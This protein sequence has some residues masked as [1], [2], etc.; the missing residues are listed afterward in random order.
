MSTGR[1]HRLGLFS[2][3][4]QYLASLMQRSD[5]GEPTYL[6]D[7][8]WNDQT[9]ISMRALQRFAQLS[10][11]GTEGPDAW[12]L[13][14]NG[15]DNDFLLK[16]GN[17]SDEG[18]VGAW[19]GGFRATLYQDVNY[20][21]DR[22]G[23]FS[24]VM[25][26]DIHHRFTR[27]SAGELVDD[28]AMWTP[29]CFQ[30]LGLS[31]SV[32][33]L[34]SFEVID[35]TATTLTLGGDF[36]GAGAT[37]EFYFF[38]LAVPAADV[39]QPVWL[40]V[41]LEDWGMA[42]DPQLNHNQDGT[43]VECARRLRLVK[44]VW[45][46]QIA[47]VPEQPIAAYR[48]HTN[49]WHYVLK[50]GALVRTGESA[51]VEVDN[52]REEN[53]SV[54]RE[55]EAARV[56]AGTCVEDA[57]QP[58]DLAERL[59]RGSTYVTV[60]T[61]SRPGMYNGPE[62]LLAALA[63]TAA[64]RRTIYLRNGTYDLAGL[65][66]LAIPA[67]V[68]LLGESPQTTI[69]VDSVGIAGASIRLGAH[70]QLC[71]LTVVGTVDRIGDA[72]VRCEGRRAKLDNVW[73][74]DQSSNGS[75]VK[76]WSPDDNATAGAHLRGV[77]ILKVAGRALDIVQSPTTSFI[78]T[79]VVGT[80]PTYGGAD[81]GSVDVSSHGILIEGCQLKS[82]SATTH[83]AD[84]A[85]IRIGSADEV[86]LRDVV[87]QVDGARAL[88]VQA[89]VASSGSPSTVTGRGRVV[90]ENFT[91]VYTPDVVFDVADSSAVRLASGE[92][93]IDG[94]HVQALTGSGAHPRTAV[95]IRAISG[96]DSMLQISGGGIGIRSAANTGLLVRGVS[97]LIGELDGVVVLPCSPTEGCNYSVRVDSTGS[98][99]FRIS[100]VRVRQ[101]SS[102]RLGVGLLG[103]FAARDIQVDGRNVAEETI[104]S[105][106]V[107]NGASTGISLQSIGLASSF[108]GGSV[109]GHGGIGAHVVS[110]VEGEPMRI[111]GVLVQG[112]GRTALGIQVTGA[113]PVELLDCDVY[114]VRGN[115]I[116]GK[117][118]TNE[119]RV[120]RG[121]VSRC[122]LEWLEAGSFPVE[123]GDLEVFDN[124]WTACL[125]DVGNIRETHVGDC[126]GAP[127]VDSDS[128][129]LVGVTGLNV[130]LESVR[131]ARLDFGVFL[132][133]AST[134]VV[135]GGDIESCT[136]SIS[137]AAT[138]VEI[139]GLKVR[140]EGQGPRLSPALGQMQ[141]CRLTD[142]DVRV[143][144]KS[145]YALSVTG[146]AP[147]GLTI[148]GGRFAVAAQ[149]SEPA[150]TVAHS[151]GGT[152][153]GFIV[154]AEDAEGLLLQDCE[155]V[156]VTQVDLTRTGAAQSARSFKAMACA[157]LRLDDV[158]AKRDVLLQD[159]HPLTASNVAVLQGGFHAQWTDNGGRV[160]HLHNVSVHNIVDRGEAAATMHANSG[161]YLGGFDA[162]AAAIELDATLVNCR[163][164][165]WKPY[166]SNFAANAPTG[167]SAGIHIRA[168]GV[169]ST[170]RL[171]G[172]SL[173][174]VSPNTQNLG[175]LVGDVNYIYES[176]VVAVDVGAQ[177]SQHVYGVGHLSVVECEFQDI[178]NESG[179]PARLAAALLASR[180]HTICGNHFENPA[181]GG[182]TN[183]IYLWR[184]MA[185]VV[186]YARVNFFGNTSTRTNWPATPGKLIQARYIQ[187][188][189][190]A[191]PDD[192]SAYDHTDFATV[193][194]IVVATWKTNRILPFIKDGDDWYYIWPDGSL[195]PHEAAD[196]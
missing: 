3:R 124:R 84:K 96:S 30:G 73:V 185:G 1:Y 26:D 133:T 132:R 91:V 180:A 59:L 17:R 65:G 187:I 35:N 177:A 22:L 51:V 142:L 40:D 191:A 194:P 15:N 163:A 80:P 100:K 77:S 97:E 11:Q 165:S 25:A 42:E 161:I 52:D 141:I 186:T 138:T 49:T 154:E 119:I 66:E 193:S 63:C 102:G 172:C 46:Q 75:A 45:V 196:P 105:G 93:W 31:V 38:D 122:G 21:C 72:V 71:N 121:N 107:A 68:V 151:P 128:F 82:M 6:T 5:P 182:W 104:S 118:L 57:D 74:W 101:H 166:G 150:V 87:V 178:D 137:G 127:L 43:P 123:S 41:H 170:V 44:R 67:N 50:I 16:G 195:G 159:C 94:L 29:H 70:A 188:D 12:K 143:S 39:V 36:P 175:V 144:G 146:C 113:H 149:T 61:T 56:F 179:P 115:G 108:C 112:E 32:G 81:A 125:R 136:R 58:R 189:G 99:P 156:R 86:V 2:E 76:I 48:D 147:G 28:H 18:L 60:G 139:D 23:G 90:L 8:D 69:T 14:A 27:I 9:R 89:E 55:V 34:G 98:T 171:K 53:A 131:L 155:D 110:G 78:D 183:L 184:E 134:L 20:A 62:G 103:T 117:S 176:G 181:A 37:H 169:N 79:S 13:E 92:V 106:A 24:E 54:A 152:L 192:L 4:R 47:D 85:C 116:V 126:G 83:S 158:Q 88:H 160:A 129:G 95:D 135:S 145:N 190:G 114:D 162:S 174:D 148:A 164:T 153:D 120:V 111:A 109:L 33:G 7:A 157:N 167:R 64:G 130:R 173:R 140:G 168:K 19:V 10:L